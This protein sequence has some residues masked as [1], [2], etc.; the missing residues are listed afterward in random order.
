MRRY[1]DTILKVL[2]HCS[3]YPPGSAGVGN[4]MR[5][6]AQAL[7]SS[8]H[9]ATVISCRTGNLPYELMEN[10]VR[11]LRM[12]DFSEKGSDRVRD[13]AISVAKDVHADVIEGADHLGDC[14]PIL[15][16]KHDIPVMVKVHACQVVKVLQDAMAYY[17][18]QHLTMAIAR[19]RAYDQM[20]NEKCSIINA[21]VMVSPTKRLMDE[22][23]KQGL[24]LP[25]KRGIVPNPITVTKAHASEEAPVPTILF[26]GRLE[27]LKGIQFLAGLMEAVLKES[28]DAVLEIAG[29]DSYARWVGSMRDWLTE[30]FGDKIKN[31]RFLGRLDE[32]QL[33]SAYARAWVVVHPSLW[34]N[35][36]T[37][38]LEAMAHGK[39][40]V[41]TPHGGMI[42][43]LEGTEC[44]IMDPSQGSF[45]EAVVS[46]L[47]DKSLR[48][49]IGGL[50]KARVI[51][52]YSP[53][54]IVP[55]YMRFVEK[56]L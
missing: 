7:V 35:F 9:Q 53:E 14:A 4:Y 42:E 29:A 18:W 56:V 22:L 27:F 28:P 49:R 32:D 52:E 54:A 19:L 1:E 36:P 38:V 10:G 24:R 47:K 12:Y 26:V 33:S 2:F 11:V 34:D 17:P 44:P 43:M 20:R 5:N 50:A 6:M 37:I 25:V 46:L 15:R 40:I 21:D 48:T 41:S 23:L 51:K 30:R 55:K 8:G 16:I 13:M 31:V 45:S 39:P 3:E